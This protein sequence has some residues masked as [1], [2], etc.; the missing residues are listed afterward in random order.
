[1]HHLDTPATCPVIGNILA[2]LNGEPAREPEFF[3]VAAV[4]LHLSDFHDDKERHTN[5][6][7][8]WD[9]Q[10]GMLG[11]RYLSADDLMARVFGP[12]A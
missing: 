5:P 6:L 2:Q 10:T 1:M 4:R 9:P 7:A 8:D 3:P 12:G 11:G